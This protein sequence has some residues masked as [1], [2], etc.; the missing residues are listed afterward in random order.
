MSA[1]TVLADDTGGRFV[2]FE[3]E[4]INLHPLLASLVLH[5]GALEQQVVL[6]VGDDVI[7]Q[8]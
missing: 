8:V 1:D 6:L 2:R 5:H 4:W 7:L 3:S